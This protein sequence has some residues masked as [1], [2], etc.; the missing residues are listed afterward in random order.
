[1]KTQ[2]TVSRIMKYHRERWGMSQRQLAKRIGVH[3]SIVNRMENGTIKVTD[4]VI[5]GL[6]FV[7]RKSFRDLKLNTIKEG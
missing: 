7:F 1:M 6:T 2:S 4:R 5:Q 3:H